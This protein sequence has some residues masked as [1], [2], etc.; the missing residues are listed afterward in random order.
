MPPF[1]FI[2]WGKNDKGSY[3]KNYEWRHSEFV[4]KV[5]VWGK[6][7]KPKAINGVAYDL[8]DP[9]GGSIVMA[10]DNGYFYTV[11]GATV[12]GAYRIADYLGSVEYYRSDSFLVGGPTGRVF[13]IRCPQGLKAAVLEDVQLPKIN[14]DGNALSRARICQTRIGARSA[15]SS[16]PG[17]VVVYGCTQNHG[18]FR[19]FHANAER[20]RGRHIAMLTMAHSVET[21]SIAVHPSMPGVFVTGG[22]DKVIQFWSATER[23][24]LASKR[25]R[26]DRGVNSIAFDGSGEFMAVGMSD[27]MVAVYKFPD[28]LFQ[29]IICDRKC[30]KGGKEYG[31]MVDVKFSA[32]LKP[33]AEQGTAPRKDAMGS[34]YLACACSDNQ[35]Y[36]LRVSEVLAGE[37]IKSGTK[38]HSPHVG[39]HK[40]LTGHSAIPYCQMFSA[41]AHYLVTNARDGQIRIFKCADGRMQKS[42]MAFRD[43]PMQLPWTNLLGWSTLGIWDMEYDLSMLDT[44]CSYHEEQLACGDEH[45]A[46]RLFQFPACY[47]N[48]PYKEYFGHAS[49]LCSV[50]FFQDMPVLISAGFTDRM[51]VQWRLAEP[52]AEV[53]G[54]QKIKYPWTVFTHGYGDVVDNTLGR[55]AAATEPGP[56]FGMQIP[57][58]GGL[59]AVPGRTMGD[60]T[61]VVPFEGDSKLFAPADRGAPGYFYNDAEAD[62]GRGPR[63]RG[64]VSPRRRL[65]SSHKRQEQSSGVGFDKFGAAKQEIDELMMSPEKPRL[66][67][68]AASGPSRGAPGLSFYRDP[69]GMTNAEIKGT[70]MIRGEREQ[71]ATMKTTGTNMLTSAMRNSTTEQHHSKDPFSWREAQPPPTRGEM[72]MAMEVDD[73][74]QTPQRP[75]RKVAFQSPLR[76]QQGDDGDRRRNSQHGKAHRGDRRTTGRSGAESNSRSRQQEAEMTSGHSK[77]NNAAARHSSSSSAARFYE[78]PIMPAEQ[79]GGSSGSKSRASNM[80]AG[81]P[82]LQGRNPITGELVR[83]PLP[84]HPQRLIGPKESKGAGGIRQPPAGELSQH[85]NDVYGGREFTFTRG[86]DALRGDTDYYGQ[87]PK[88][89]SMEQPPRGGG[90]FFEGVPSGP[91]HMVNQVLRGGPSLGGRPGFSSTA[92][93]RG[94]FQSIGVEEPRARARDGDDHPPRQLSMSMTRSVDFGGTTTPTA[95]AKKNLLTAAARRCR[96]IANK[97]RR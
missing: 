46:V 78:D 47:L 91:T 13:V 56:A 8:D 21:R 7:P 10:G 43:L 24:A 44:C 28:S 30:E 87:N 33:H 83:D 57:P 89:A 71:D 53:Y 29:R 40:V 6:F 34:M 74:L 45:G 2:L 52:I 76:S 61:S 82:H 15:H 37:D 27:G 69:P 64:E 23:K 41:D 1:R 68:A 67:T 94:D 54:F 60:T 19:Y 77:D 84:G 11:K 50:R 65:A 25:L 72:M 38:I 48:Q 49:P 22:T 55:Y 95:G 14:G 36:M 16:D 63:S 5:G 79:A 62:E 75:P 18:L 58:E 59:N 4:T 66:S 3:F 31:R 12:V 85:P 81:P 26:M 17:E 20:S 42:L 93:D 96:N 32:R 80:Q 9:T 92:V 51:V 70:T 39:M 35:V 86:G 90:N 88:R 73:D 97:Q